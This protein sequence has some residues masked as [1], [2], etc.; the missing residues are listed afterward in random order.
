MSIISGSAA[1]STTGSSG[2][3]DFPISQSL[4]FDGS[5]YL[6][7]TTN[8]SSYLSSFVFSAWIKRSVLS[9]SNRQGIFATDTATNH[10]SESAG[11]SGYMLMF[12]S[13]S[14]ADKLHLTGYGGS[15]TANSTALFRD[16]SSWYHI[17]WYVYQT[18]NKV[19][20]NN[21]E[22]ISLSAGAGVDTFKFAKNYIGARSDISSYTDSHSPTDYLKGYIAEVNL[23]QDGATDTTVQS[24]PSG[25]T[26]WADAFGET[27]NGVWTPKDPSGLTYGANGFRLTFDPSN[28]TN[29]YSGKGNH[30][31][32]TGF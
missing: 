32:A 9:G 12:N 20:V 3:Y 2:F 23:L 21:T 26:T 1:I 10:T 7:R 11:G 15:Y 30:W 25:A 31:T 22:V 29:D 27:K 13:G 16:T 4:M 24:P 8:V 17:V 28:P 18:T 5:S 6:T 19:Y 14:D